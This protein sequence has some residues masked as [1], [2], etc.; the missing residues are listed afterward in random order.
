VFRNVYRFQFH[1]KVA[2]EIILKVIPRKDFSDLDKKKFLDAIYQR[3]GDDLQV[4][5]EQ[6]GE[7]KL[8]QRGK[9]KLLIQELLIEFGDYE[10][11]SWET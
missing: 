9:S 5:F 8:T 6:V 3:V 7:I 1:Q 11:E 2:G 10:Y 4:I